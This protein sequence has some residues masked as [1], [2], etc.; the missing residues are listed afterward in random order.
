MTKPITAT[1]KDIKTNIH[2]IDENGKA[3]TKNAGNRLEKKTR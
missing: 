3:G 2:K 1:K